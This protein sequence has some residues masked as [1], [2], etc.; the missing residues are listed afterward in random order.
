MSTTRATRSWLK[1]KGLSSGTYLQQEKTGEK[2][3]P[4]SSALFC[5]VTLHVTRKKLDNVLL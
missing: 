2:S 3:A 4:Q 5:I 1:V